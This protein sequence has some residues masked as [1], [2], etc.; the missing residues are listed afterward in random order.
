MRP[1]YLPPNV[2]ALGEVLAKHY[3][4][5]FRWLWGFSRTPQAVLARRRWLAITCWTL[6][7]SSTETACMFGC[8]HTT[9]LLACSEVEKSLTATARRAR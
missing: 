5:P 7:L 1:E 2:R 9:V 3:G 4:I 6:G 8:D